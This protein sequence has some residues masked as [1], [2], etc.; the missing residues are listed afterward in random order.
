MTPSSVAPAAMAP[1]FTASAAT[2][3][4]NSNNVSRSYWHLGPWRRNVCPLPTYN[5]GFI[6]YFMVMAKK[7]CY[8]KFFSL[9]EAL[10]VILLLESTIE[11]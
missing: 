3:I 9:V 1:A 11:M 2:I 4:T 10:G 8:A 5:P 7:G 6:S